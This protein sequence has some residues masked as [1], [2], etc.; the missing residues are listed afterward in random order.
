MV[1]LR[2]KS[3]VK[4]VPLANSASRRTKKSWRGKHFKIAIAEI[5]ELMAL[6]WRDLKWRFFILEPSALKLYSYKL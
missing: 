1:K 3:F 6:A 2:V 4:Q 5:D